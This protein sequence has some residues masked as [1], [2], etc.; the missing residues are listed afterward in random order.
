MII[1]GAKGFAKE[2]L[3][4]LHQNN[5]LHGLAFYDDVNQDIPDVLF[6]QFPVL[7][8]ESQVKAHFFKFGNAFTIGI[9]GP[10]LRKKIYDK[11]IKIGGEL[12]STISKNSDIGSYN[13]SIKEGC[14]ILSGAIISNSSII[15]RS[16]IIYY[17]VIITH[18]VEVGD[19]VEISPGVKLLGKCVVGNFSSIGSNAVVLPNVK[20]GNNVIVGAGAVVSKD[21]PDNCVAVG[22]PAKIIKTNHD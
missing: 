14:N 7:R 12:S 8:N 18:D 9:G 1:V 5:Q 17:N 11:F 10:Q 4:V 3:E 15:G 20:I 6:G 16:C 19:Y 21:L 2:V 13:I 22:V